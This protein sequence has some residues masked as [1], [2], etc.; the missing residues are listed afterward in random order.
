VRWLVLESAWV[1]QVQK[2]CLFSIKGVG[3]DQVFIMLSLVLVNDYF[4]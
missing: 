2:W 1:M 4:S 3:R